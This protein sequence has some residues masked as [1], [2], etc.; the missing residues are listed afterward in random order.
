MKRYISKIV[1]TASLLSF[2]VAVIQALI[3]RFGGSLGK[4]LYF[5]ALIATIGV[6]FLG[7]YRIIDLLEARR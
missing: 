5:I 3:S 7:L 1:L 2:L 4:D 6:L